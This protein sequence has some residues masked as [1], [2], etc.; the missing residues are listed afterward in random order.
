MGKWCDCGKSL[1]SP[2]AVRKV[3]LSLLGHPDDAEFLCAGTLVRLVDAGWQIHIATATPGDCGTIVHD[4][5]EISAIRT[6]EA[7]AAAKLIGASYH[8]LGEGDGLVIYEKPT[9]QKTV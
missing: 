8:C 3:A 1:Q 9:I 2:L 5:F 4:R 7:A 6:K